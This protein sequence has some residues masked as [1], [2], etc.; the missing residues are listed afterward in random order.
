MNTLSRKGVMLWCFGA[1]CFVVV[2]EQRDNSMIAVPY[3][4]TPYCSTYGTVLRVKLLG[5][6]L[7]GQI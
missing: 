6:S 4:G 2:V 7:S 5:C 3:L 1:S